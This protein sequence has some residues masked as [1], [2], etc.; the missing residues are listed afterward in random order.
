MKSVSL[1]GCE[2]IYT[3]TQGPYWFYWKS[4]GRQMVLMQTSSSRLLLMPSIKADVA[5]M[6]GFFTKHVDPAVALR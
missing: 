2:E 3:F 1:E 5:K 4:S 6:T